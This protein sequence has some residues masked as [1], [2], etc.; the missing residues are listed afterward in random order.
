MHALVFLKCL[1]LKATIYLFFCHRK[2]YPHYGSPAL[3]SSYS[4]PPQALCTV[5]TLSS[6]L[7]LPRH[8][9]NSYVF[10]ISSAVHSVAVAPAT[11]ISAPV[12]L[13][14]L[15]ARGWP[16]SELAKLNSPSY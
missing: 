16:Q 11:I 14:F 4:Y 6:L 8:R 12:R 9:D 2:N 3:E 13:Q 10:T 5:L 15:S 1:Q 7:L